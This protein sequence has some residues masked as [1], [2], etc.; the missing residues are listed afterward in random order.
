MS[1]RVREW[2]ERGEEEG[3]EAR[4]KTAECRREEAKERCGRT[5][6]I[7][8]R[9]RFSL[10]RVSFCSRVSQN[11]SRVSV[12]GSDQRSHGIN[13]LSSPAVSNPLFPSYFRPIRD[14][15][16][17]I[18]NISSNHDYSYPFNPR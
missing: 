12:A 5:C 2:E 16:E 8:G 18:K 1:R 4:L 7:N 14:R 6:V 13:L 9:F 15:N 11:G 10:S 17:A 3:E